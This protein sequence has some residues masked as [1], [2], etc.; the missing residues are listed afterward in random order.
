MCGQLEEQ[1]LALVSSS[2]V[3]LCTHNG[4][5]N[6]LCLQW[7]IQRLSCAWGRWRKSLTVERASRKA[8]DHC[9]QLLVKQVSSEGVYLFCRASV[10]LH[11]QAQSQQAV[12]NLQF[13][14]ICRMAG[15][16]LIVTQREQL[17]INNNW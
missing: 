8:V 15:S 7:K 14:D 5:E 10:G 13:A 12:M 2:H 1:A 4:T 6:M 16:Q 17:S 11:V 9:R 3:C